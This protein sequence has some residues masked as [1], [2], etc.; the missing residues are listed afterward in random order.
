MAMTLSLLTPE[1]EVHEGECEFVVIPA[2]GGEMGVL[3]KHAP[4]VAAL[5]IG[6]LRV[7]EG[8]VLKRYGVYGGI[9]Q[10]L[11][12]RVTVLAQAA[13]AADEIDAAEAKRELDEI[14]AVSPG[15]RDPDAFA[16]A[17]TRVR[18]TQRSG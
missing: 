3:P 17:R 8:G 11:D 9:V 12:D 2:Q 4:I 10:V 15:K 16:R 1:R 6:E 14:T 13:E 5:G 18:L 7:K